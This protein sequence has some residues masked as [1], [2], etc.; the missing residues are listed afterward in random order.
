MSNLLSTHN[1]KSESFYH[2]AIKRLFFK[3]VSE[4]NKDIIEKSLE[5]YLINRRADVYF[6]FKSGEEIVV[7][8]QNSNIT[9]K[10]ITKNEGREEEEK[11]GRRKASFR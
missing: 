8:V 3:Y 2:K 7:E 6:R 1:A 11:R 9:V 4:N 10:E 5:K